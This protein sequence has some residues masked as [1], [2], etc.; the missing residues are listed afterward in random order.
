MANPDRTANGPADPKQALI[1]V[2]A[3]DPQNPGDK[4]ILVTTR[5]A[6]EGKYQLPDEFRL[7]E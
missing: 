7:R 2:V 5:S 1:W 6:A 4:A 3:D